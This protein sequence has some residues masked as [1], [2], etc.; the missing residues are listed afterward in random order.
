MTIKRLKKRYY[1]LSFFIAIFISAI[2]IFSDQM[3]NV[4]TNIPYDKKSSLNKK[5]NTINSEYKIL[6]N[7]KLNIQKEN[8]DYIDYSIN[9]NLLQK[10]ISTFLSIFSKKINLFSLKIVDIKLSKKYYNVA[11]ITIH[12]ISKSDYIT[13]K[14]VNK[15][16]K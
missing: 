10:K 5:L 8:K 11:N 16:K 9:K 2:I 14:F 15:R 13:Q 4:F 1:G 12:G 7:N 3:F 6:I